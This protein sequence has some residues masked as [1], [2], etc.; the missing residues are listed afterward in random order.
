MQE[1][2]QGLGIMNEKHDFLHEIAH[3]SVL[4]QSD[5]WYDYEPA[6][7]DMLDYKLFSL[8]GISL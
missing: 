1:N 4:W 5:S 3:S 7:N 6:G 8:D 2:A